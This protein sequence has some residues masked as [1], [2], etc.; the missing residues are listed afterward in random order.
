MSLTNISCAVLNDLGRHTADAG[1]DERLQLAIEH[2]A[3]LMLVDTDCCRAL[4]ESFVEQL[5]S[6][7]PPSLM[8]Q[9]YLGVGQQ[10]LRRFYDRNPMGPELGELVRVGRAFVAASAAATLDKRVEDERKAA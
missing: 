6:D 10:M 1:R 8:D 3:D 4:G 7:A 9:F 2:E 5:L